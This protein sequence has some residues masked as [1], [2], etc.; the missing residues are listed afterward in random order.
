MTEA[1][2]FISGWPVSL[3]AVTVYLSVCAVQDLRRR[4]ISLRWSVCMGALALAADIAKAM[5]FLNTSGNTTPGEVLSGFLLWL[6]CLAPGCLL[7]I[8]SA[9]AEGSAGAGDGIC[10]LVVGAFTDARTAWI[11]LAASLFLASVS[12]IVL[13]CLKKADRKTRL[14]FLAFVGAA[15]GTGLLVRLCQV[16]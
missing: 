16:K 2:G 10:F 8:L 9:A 15:W 13:M 1:F 11:L 4:R 5:A 7:L 12:G 3:P 6:S 14:P